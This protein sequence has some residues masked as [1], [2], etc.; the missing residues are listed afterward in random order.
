M[1]TRLAE[2]E[3]RLREATPGPWEGHISDG[4][5]RGPCGPIA[6]MRATC[7]T[8]QW[9]GDIELIANAPSDL[10]YLLSRLKL[11]EEV[12]EA[13]REALEKM[14]N[15]ARKAQGLITAQPWYVE[16]MF[17][18]GVALAALSAPQAAPEKP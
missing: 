2:I 16:A 8:D 11:A 3:K 4:S 1:T 18:V 9:C 5:L 10:A 7:V 12:V 6:Y 13:A 15:E 14:R 17:H